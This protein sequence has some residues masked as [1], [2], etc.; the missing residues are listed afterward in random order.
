MNLEIRNISGEAT[1]PVRHPV[2]RA[3]RPI[4]DCCFKGDE[5]STTFHVGAF[6]NDKIVAVATFLLHKDATIEEIKHHTEEQCYQLRGMAVLEEIQGKQVGK[7]LLE[8]GEQFLRNK[9]VSALWFNARVKAVPFYEKL[10][11]QVI[12]DAFEIEPIGTHYKMYKSL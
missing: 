6:I 11:Y 1:Y 4:E 7:K 10:G 8:Y 3:G 9:K 2:L 5:L 12:S